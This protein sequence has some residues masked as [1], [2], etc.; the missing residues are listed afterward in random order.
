MTTLIRSEIVSRGLG[1]LERA[2][3]AE[4]AARSAR[5]DGPV[6]FRDRPHR[7]G[8]VCLSSADLCRK[9]FWINGIVLG[10]SGNVVSRGIIRK[11]TAAEYKALIRAMHSLVATIVLAKDAS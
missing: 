7:G 9:I 1:K 10:E 8:A 5:H 11:E 6:L 3:L 2:I 4:I